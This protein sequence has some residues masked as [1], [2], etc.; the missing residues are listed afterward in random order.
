MPKITKK[1][2]TSELKRIAKT[3]ESMNLH[4]WAALVSAALVKLL[5]RK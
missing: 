1:Y 4:K 3:P 2:V 5:E